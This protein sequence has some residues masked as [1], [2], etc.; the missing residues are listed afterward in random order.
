MKRVVVPELLDSDS[1]TREEVS[2]SLHDL[3]WLN[4]NF[5]GISTTTALLRSVAEKKRLSRMTMLDVAGASGDVAN[6][7]ATRLKR[8]GI[9]IDVTIADRAVS[10]LGKDNTSV[11]ADAFALPFRDSS[12]DVVSCALF[13]HHLEPEQIDIFLRESLR[14]AKHAVIVNDLQRGFMHL[15]AAFLG[16]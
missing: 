13:L 16:R 3:Q 9:E 8:L 6:G 14:V 1:G 4:R 15:A 11:V 2:D 5:G 10:H 7:A 12:Y